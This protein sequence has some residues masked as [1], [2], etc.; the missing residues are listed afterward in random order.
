MATNAALVSAKALRREPREIAAGLG[1]RWSA[2]EGAAV[3]DRVEVAGPGFLNLL[4]E[5]RLV[6]RRR[7]PHPGQGADYGRDVLP[8]ARAPRSTSS[9]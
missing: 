8:E 6:P 2:G 5:R 1:A 4:L 9:S 7:R 3:C